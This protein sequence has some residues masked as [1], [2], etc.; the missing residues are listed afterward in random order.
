MLSG[1]KKIFFYFLAISALLLS[2]KKKKSD[3]VYSNAE[4]SFGKYKYVVRDNAGNEDTVEYGIYGNANFYPYSESGIGGVFI[5]DEQFD[6]PHA[7]SNHDPGAQYRWGGFNASESDVNSYQLIK[8]KVIS[9]NQ[10]TDLDYSMNAIPFYNYTPPY[11]ISCSAGFSIVIDAASLP[12]ADSI[13]IAISNNE[14]VFDTTLAIVNGTIIISPSALSVL[15][16]VDNN[17]KT[18]IGVYAWKSHNV[19]IN[20]KLFAL[21]NGSGIGYDI[22]LNP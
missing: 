17:H 21:K 16:P 6:G 18:T 14:H 4:I 11:N 15:N 20:N 19:S 9:P 7:P 12:G 5:N 1:M 13:S 10:A 2:C 3:S 8:L 22:N